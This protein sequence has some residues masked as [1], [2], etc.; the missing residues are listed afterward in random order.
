MKKTSISFAALFF[1]SI[2]FSQPKV[3]D[4]RYS[5][6]PVKNQ[7]DRGTCTAFAVA[8][9]LETFPG[10]PSDLSEQYLYAAL[11]MMDYDSSLT[12]VEKGGMLHLYKESLKKFGVFHEQ[13]M[14]YNSNQLEFKNTDPNL[15]QV[16]RESQTGPVS[17]L[18]KR[19]SAKAGIIGEADVEWADIPG[20]QDVD[21]IKKLLQ[22]GVKAVA[23]SYHINPDEFSAIQKG[24]KFVLVPDSSFL[25]KDIAED[26]V[27]FFWDA[28]IKYGSNFFEKFKKKE[29]SLWS[30]FNLDGHAMTVVGYNEKGFIIK[31]S[32]GKNFGD[33]GYITISYD[34]HRLLAR[35][36]FAIKKIHYFKP[37]QYGPLSTTTDLRLKVIP[38]SGS[39]GLSLSL[40]CV[41]DQFDPVIAVAGYSI[42]SIVGGKRTF[43]EKQT[44]LAPIEG[45]Y[46]NSLEV[47]VLKNRI[48]GLDYLLNNS[49]YEVEVSIPVTP[50]KPALKRVYK[51]I[52]LINNEYKA[53]GHPVQPK[54]KSLHLEQKGN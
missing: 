28:R 30:P 22:E 13:L 3:I 14:P 17:M 24:K 38:L 20:G 37:P 29:I 40:F 18:L 21:R 41:N 1:Y 34:Y 43:I 9:C 50:G 27:Y 31:N 25:V 11:K 44:A 4:Y 8:A 10:V 42:Y 36:M 51:N 19:P 46:N 12:E 54:L 45:E 6:S 48:M 53:V 15:V 49:I 32:W 33:N 35:R 2:I 39:N 52:R 5:Q 23:V 47:S 7:E 16:I 26:T